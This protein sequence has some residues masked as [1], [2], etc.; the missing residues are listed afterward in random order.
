VFGPV[1]VA[2]PVAG[3]PVVVSCWKP[4]AAELAEI[5]RTGRV[6]LYVW[7]VS[8]PPCV[9]SGHHPWSPPPEPPEGADRGG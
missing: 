6:W 2:G 1:G 9:V 8:M 4:D 5:N 3:V 7:G